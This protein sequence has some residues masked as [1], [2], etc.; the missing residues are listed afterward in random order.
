MTLDL[1][2]LDPPPGKVV[3]NLPYGV[4][5]TVLLRT[6][7]ELPGV[8]RCGWPW[9]SARWPSA[10]PR[11]RA[12]RPTAPPRCSRSWHA[13]C[14]RAAPGAAHRLPPG[15]Q[16]G[17]GAR[18][19]APPRPLRP[20]R[21]CVALVHA[22]FAHRRKA[23]AGSLALAAGAPDGIRD[24]AREALEELGHPADARA[25]RL[26]P[27]GLR[28]AGRAARRTRWPAL[29]RRDRAAMS[30]GR[31]RPGQG[32]PRAARGRARARTGC[33]RCAPCSPRSTS[34]TSVA[35]ERGRR[36]TRWSAPA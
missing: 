34:R 25:E 11:G 35:V 19:H 24:R 32:Q 23:L 36:R 2:A 16:R 29:G 22:A 18:A 26:A 10:W 31:A 9:C 13:R 6:V 33:T 7:A 4:A 3:A 20:A 28:G 27:R 17:V 8:R 5:A 1:G 14:K 12:A 21:R 15:A 30:V